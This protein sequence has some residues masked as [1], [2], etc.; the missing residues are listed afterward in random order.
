MKTKSLLPQ[1]LIIVLIT[2]QNAAYSQTGIRNLIRGEKGLTAS[3]TQL[4][5]VESRDYGAFDPSKV[6]TLLGIDKY[7]ELVLTR[8]ETDQLGEVHYRY[9]QAYKGIPV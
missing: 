9:S 6:K 5:P 2:F 4:S 7:S 8:K 1:L 3:F